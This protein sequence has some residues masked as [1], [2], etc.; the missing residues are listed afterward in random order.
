MSREVQT[1]IAIL[2]LVC[3]ACATKEANWPTLYRL[4]KAAGPA[5]TQSEG[6]RSREPLRLAPVRGPAWVQKTDIFYCLNYKSHTKLAPYGHSEWIAPPTQMVGDAVRRQLIASGYWRAVLDAEDP[7]GARRILRLQLGE[8]IHVFESP[9]KS[10]GQLHVTAV[11][12]D[13]AS[14]QAL[15]QRHFTYRVSAP[16][17]DAAG[18][19][20][21]LSR[22]VKRLCHD[23]QHWLL[24]Q[25]PTPA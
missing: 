1:V 3:T 9:Q 2:A 16:S 24:T 21:A 5:Q 20:Q 17:A 22:A 6:D 18:G 4:V 19:V 12:I 14:H 10:F 7:A 15:A 8:L 11:L 23:L 25:K 13:R